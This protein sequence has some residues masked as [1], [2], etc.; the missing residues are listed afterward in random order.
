MQVVSDTNIIVAAF[1]KKGDTRRLLFSK[2]FEI[3]SPDRIVFEILANKEEFKQKGNMNE[4]EFQ[5]AL[6]LELENIVIIPIEEYSLFKKKALSICPSGH[7]DDW[8][9]FALALKLNCA[10]W[11]ND[12]ALKKQSDISVYSTTELLKL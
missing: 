9:F 3:F 8:P 10:L 4:D 1:L 7:E 2:Q 6:E 12:L 11:S 5:Q